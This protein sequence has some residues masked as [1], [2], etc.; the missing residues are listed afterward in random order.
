M[1]SKSKKSN[2]RWKFV[3]FILILLII[4]GILV[5]GFMTKWKFTKSQNKTTIK[6]PPLPPRPRPTLEPT[7]EPN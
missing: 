6:K 4:I 1:K 2:K 7:L 3:L 5:W